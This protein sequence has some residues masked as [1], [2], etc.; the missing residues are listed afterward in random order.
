MM[1][2]S[3]AGG[4]PDEEVPK[5][6]IKELLKISQQLALIDST[7]I[8]QEIT[9]IE[10]KAFLEI[11][12]SPAHGRGECVLTRARQPRHWLRY[13]FVSGRK[14]PKVDSI[15]RFNAIS[16]RLADWYVLSCH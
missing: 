6:Q 10:A 8:A 14:D 15:A 2:S 1:N 11:E 13:T 4:Q 7:E 9:R 16:E 5:H 12:V 3:S